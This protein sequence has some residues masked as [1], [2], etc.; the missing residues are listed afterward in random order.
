MDC[1]H[2][3]SAVTTERS[4]RTVLGYRKF[5]CRHCDRGFNERTG[6]P[7][8]W[9]QYPTD[10]VLLVVL[11]RLRYKLSLRDLAEMF[12]ER[13]FVFTH[14]TVRDW[15]AKLA[16]LMAEQLRKRRRGVV[17]ESWYVDETYIKVDG[18]WCY[19]YRAIE[20]STA[21]AI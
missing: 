15:E 18:Q 19:L 21:T 3:G 16:P 2:C 1:P 7:Y 12:L 11:W 17:G 8:N 4:D 13:G 5:R 6:T 14:E 20:L 9:L 10:I